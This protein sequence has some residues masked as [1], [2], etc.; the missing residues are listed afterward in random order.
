MTVAIFFQQEK[1]K[2]NEILMNYGGDIRKKRYKFNQSEKL[3]N[4]CIF[5]NMYHH[6]DAIIKFKLNSHVRHSISVSLSLRTWI[7]VHWVKSYGQRTKKCKLLI[8][9][10]HP[11]EKVDFSKTQ[12]P[13]EMLLITIWHTNVGDY[14]DVKTFSSILHL[15]E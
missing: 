12:R 4:I 1:Y 11:T 8:L 3:S 2:I 6:G 9:T 15:P 13:P 5:F 7:L 10:P 14:A